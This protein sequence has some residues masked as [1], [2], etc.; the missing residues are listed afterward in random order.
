[1]RL[2]GIDISEAQGEIDFHKL[3]DS[4]K[5]DFIFAKATEG[6]TIQDARF[7]EYH[8]KAKEV[9]IPFGPYH[10]F[11]FG[12]STPEDQAANFLTAISGYEGQLLPM[13]DV[14]SG[15][16]DHVKDPQIM[17][18]RLS[19]FLQIVEKTLNGK[20]VIIYCGYSFW[21]DVLGG[22]DCFSGHLV[23]P[24]AYTDHEIDPTPRGFKTWALWQH[25][26]HEP[27]LGIQHPVDGDYLNGDISLISRS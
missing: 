13:V 23:W 2:S 24:A 17:I 22:P 7:K 15:S 11:H 20:K 12:S 5:V 4:G 3:K 21:N 18:K 25:T 16:Q 19:A 1:M 10:F 8:N 9:D 27:E 26:D 14:E 6:R